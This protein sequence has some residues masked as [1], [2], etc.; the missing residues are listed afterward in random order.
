MPN[1][2]KDRHV[3]AAAV[4]SGAPRVVTNNLKHFKN[5]DLTKVE[6]ESIGPD[7]FLCEMLKRTPNLVEDALRRHAAVIRRPRPWT[8]PE[9]LGRF[10]GL[11]RGDP[12]APCF[13]V[14]VEQHLGFVPAPP[15]EVQR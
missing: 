8:V 13:A 5:Q 6:K 15:P 1:D 2:P 9:L 10:A 12:L 14:L 3:L 11:G 7:D 4:V